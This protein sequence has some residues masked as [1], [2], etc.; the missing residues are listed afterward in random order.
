MEFTCLH[1]RGNNLLHCQLTEFSMVITSENSRMEIPYLAIYKI[2][3]HK[4]GRYFYATIW[5]EGFKPVY[6]SNKTVEDKRVVEQSP[7]YATFLRV[8]HFHLKKKGSKP[9]IRAA[10]ASTKIWLSASLFI[11]V[12][13]FVAYFFGGLLNVAY[14]N[15]IF[16]GLMVFLSLFATL[17]LLAFVKTSKSEEEFPAGYLPA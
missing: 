9:L 16:T 8:L 4:A 15:Y 12:L 17:T 5:A 14:L 2:T 1:N 3:V 13:L 6:V 10:T 7:A 11:S